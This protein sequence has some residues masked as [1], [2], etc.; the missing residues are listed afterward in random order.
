MTT[1]SPGSPSM[2]SLAR[3][4][5][6]RVLSVAMLVN[7][8]GN[9]LFMTTSALLFTRAVGMS[10]AQVGFALALGGVFGIAAGVPMGRVADRFGSRPTVVALLGA[11]GV[12]ILGYT[13]VHSFWAAVPL[14]CGVTFLDRGASAVRNALVAHALP[15]ELRMPGRAFLRM[16]T[17]AGVG[18]GAALA[19]LALVVDTPFAYRTIVVLDAVTFVGA[20]LLLT[21]VPGER[22]AKGAAASGGRA[23]GALTDVP[24][25][26]ITLLSGVL[27]LQ[28]GIM[29]VGI[30]L[31]VTRDTHA[32]RLL[33]SACLV[34]NTA[35]VIALQVRLTRGAEDPARAARICLR[36]GTLMAVG[37]LLF[38]LAKGPDAWTASILVLAALAL[39]TV[40]EVLCAAGTWALSYELADERAHGVYQGVFNSGFAAG[41]LLGPLVVTQT[42]LRFGMTGWL[43][44]GAVFLVAAFAFIPAT[45]WAAANRPSWE[46]VPREQEVTA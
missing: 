10:P 30:P 14:I 32:P 12:L 9:G 17:N 42:A 8:L 1:T 25:L 18:V 15:A 37:C 27:V 38:G 31:W 21:R 7:T 23:F 35:M 20:A 13:Q 41:V 2:A 22:P 39:Q 19:S 46:P 44:F 34:L 16:M 24:Y 29:E 43:V 33:V 40:G 28:Q 4:P 36:A 26:V 45:R 5:V 11:E 6:I 3:H